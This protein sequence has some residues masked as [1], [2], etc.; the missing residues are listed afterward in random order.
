MTPPQK[1]CLNCY[2]GFCSFWPQLR[3]PCLRQQ[4]SSLPREAPWHTALPALCSPPMPYTHLTA[5]PLRWGFCP[6]SGCTQGSRKGKARGGAAGENNRNS[7]PGASDTETMRTSQ[8]RHPPNEI[9]FRLHLPHAHVGKS[10]CV[11]S[12]YVCINKAFTI[13]G[14]GHSTAPSQRAVLSPAHRAWLRLWLP[15]PTPP[16]WLA[17]QPTTA[18]CVPHLAP[19]PSP[20]HHAASR[21]C[22]KNHQS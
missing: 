7:K 12:W 10:Q 6:R 2:R 4:I 3:V 16:S 22:S 18:G 13:S 1:E 11:N 17:V 21:L 20:A 15:L 8:C 9:W 19:Q 14:M 5:T